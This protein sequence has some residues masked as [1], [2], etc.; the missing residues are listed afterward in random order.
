M[1]LGRRRR[2]AAGATRLRR[3]YKGKVEEIIK[4]ALR[5]RSMRLGEVTT[6]GTYGSGTTAGRAIR[7]SGWPSLLVLWGTEENNSS[8]GGTNSKKIFPGPGK[9]APLVNAAPKDLGEFQKVAGSSNTSQDAHWRK[10][11]GSPSSSHG[12]PR[13]LSRSSYPGWLPPN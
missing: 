6:G 4:G 1:L 2:G 3:R 13:F 9:G 11:Q 12:P 7:I 10:Q 8:S 5:A